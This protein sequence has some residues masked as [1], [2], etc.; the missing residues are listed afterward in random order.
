MRRLIPFLLVAALAGTACGTSIR[1]Q[2]AQ[3]LAEANALFMRGCHSCLV[4]AFD[5]YSA[6]RGE[7]FQPALVTGKAF[8]AAIL[9]AARE[10]ELAMEATSWIE[11]AE[12]LLSSRGPVGPRYLEMVNALPWA[13]GRHDRDFRD[14]AMIAVGP[15]LDALEKWDAALGPAPARDIVGTYLMAAA[16]CAFT[17]ARLQPNLTFDVLAP[18]HGRTPL[19]QYAAGICSPE[20]RSHLDALAGDADFHEV[21]YQLGR[22]RLYQGG[23]TVH[24]DAR[25]LLEAGHTAMPD[26]IAVTWLLASVL[27]ALEEHEACAAMYDE[28][29][30]RGGA[31]RESM[32]NRTVCLTRAAKRPEAIRSATEIIDTPGI[33]RGEAYFWRAWNQYHAKNLPVARVD[34]ESA[35][36]LFQDADVYALSGFIAYD[37]DQ[38]DYAYTEFAE[39]L[40]RNREYCVAAF[41]QGLID[42]QK[43]QWEPAAGRYVSATGCY[44]RSVRRLENDLRQAHAL[45]ADNPTRERRIRNLT[46]GL[47]VEKLQLAR[48]AYN[49]AYSYGRHG[50]AAKGLPYAEQA[51]A[52]HRDMRK[53][54]EELLEILRK[55]G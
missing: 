42:S 25:V 37:M 23:A 7:G 49:V 44:E 27:S 3:R 19:M 33:L 47:D 10:K 40:R 48:A 32:L 46:E 43:E 18:A 4:R 2:Q 16:R 21:T 30:R 41:Y 5:T 26:A 20:L 13:L 17:P 35:K 1:K 11:R 24:L 52:A 51:A 14:G 50:D 38:K 29:I 28:V 8:D 39:A 34:V 55:A 45:D 53:L 22:L 9:L 36:T 54:A 15:V 12:G 31:R 6:L